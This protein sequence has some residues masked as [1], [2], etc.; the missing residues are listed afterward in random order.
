[1]S[2]IWN[3]IQYAFK[4]DRKLKN[5]L[6]V[7]FTSQLT[8]EF[9]VVLPFSVLISNF[10]VFYPLNSM[11]SIRWSR[12]HIVHEGESNAVQKRLFKVSDSYGVKCVDVVILAP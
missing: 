11:E 10:L 6:S 12:Q 2:E 3:D 4:D 1:M 5:Q 8:F 7:W 9:Y